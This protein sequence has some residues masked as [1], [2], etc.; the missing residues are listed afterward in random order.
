M[1]PARLSPSCSLRRRTA[2]STGI[3]VSLGS[4]QDPWSLPSDPASGSVFPGA[5]ELA[6][7]AAPGW[8]LGGWTSPPG[9]SCSW[10]CVCPTL[11]R[12]TWQ[13]GRQSVLAESGLVVYLSHQMLGF[14]LPV[15]PVSVKGTLEETLEEMGAQAV[16]AL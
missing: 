4:H 14:G 5:L 7:P 10:L 3:P 8:V 11:P 1:P 15:K 2:V 12:G 9:Q 13:T 6:K 16:G